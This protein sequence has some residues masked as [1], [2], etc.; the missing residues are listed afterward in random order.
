MLTKGRLILISLV[1]AAV[2]AVSI[3][4]IASAAGPYN[5]NGNTPRMG[6]QTGCGQGECSEAV[7][8]LLG[9]T[10]DQIQDLRNEGQSL[11][12]I[13]A[14]RGVTEQQLVDAIMTER[15]TAIEDRVTAGT[16]T[17]EQADLM[18][19]QMEQNV[20]KAVNRTST[21]KPE[22][23]GTGGAGQGMCGGQMRNQQSGSGC[24]GESGSCIGSGKA[25]RWGQGF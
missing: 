21:G 19:Q 25:H 23:S 24:N 5:S 10:A 7:R 9:L 13:A 22:W 8:D 6:Q 2:L 11:V 15:R 1:L 4:V 20:V 14:D 3:P 18:L 17:R 16:L 12:Q